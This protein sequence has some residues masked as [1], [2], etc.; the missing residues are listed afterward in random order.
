MFGAKRKAKEKLK[1]Q[2]T[3]KQGD[4][5]R[6]LRERILELVWLG[7]SRGEKDRKELPVQKEFFL[8][9]LKRVSSPDS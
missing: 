8:F 4:K 5:Q 6:S 2:N 7:F 3:H 1:I 9:T